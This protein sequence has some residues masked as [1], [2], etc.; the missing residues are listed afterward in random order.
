MTFSTSAEQSGD[1]PAQ[2]KQLSWR[3][4]DSVDGKD[5]HYHD[6]YQQD[7]LYRHGL[8]LHPLSNLISALPARHFG[9]TE[10]PTPLKY[11]DDEKNMRTQILKIAYLPLGHFGCFFLFLLGLL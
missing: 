11:R 5:E 1:S 9:H 4:P 7:T 2:S 10:P 8:F 3:K 6:T